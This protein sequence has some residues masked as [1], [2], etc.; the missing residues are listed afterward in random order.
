MCYVSKHM[1]LKWIV[2]DY[3]PFSLT[4]QIFDFFSRN[5][6]FLFERHL[7]HDI[8]I[9]GYLYF[10]QVQARYENINENLLSMIFV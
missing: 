7:E 4:E 1:I 9:K 3:Q 6:E 8:M 2:D 5:S 10:Y